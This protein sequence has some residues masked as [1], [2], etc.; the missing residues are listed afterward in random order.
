MRDA[1]TASAMT[2]APPITHASAV[3]SGR[4]HHNG[5][6][7]AVAGDR[8]GGV[9][10]WE[11]RAGRTDQTV[12]EGRTQPS[13][14][15]L[16]DRDRDGSSSSTCGDEERVDVAMSECERCCGACDHRRNDPAAA[17]NCD[18]ASTRREPSHTV[19]HNEVQGVSIDPDDEIAF[20]YRVR[21][22]HEDRREHH[23]SRSDHPE[24]NPSPHGDRAPILGHFTN[25]STH[26]RPD[27][28]HLAHRSR[29]AQ[30]RR[31]GTRKSRRSRGCDRAHGLMGLGRRVTGAAASCFRFYGA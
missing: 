8:L 29:P 5:S 25:R 13:N 1:P 6:E 7:R 31:S 24:R 3:R 12:G 11:R 26:H 21:E 28:R 19:V 18:Q 27:P 14:C 10:G 20:A 22:L 23:E 30:S 4:C 2:A 16:H 17:D 9:T 15:V